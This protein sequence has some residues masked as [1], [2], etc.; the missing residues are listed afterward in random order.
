MHEEK[1]HNS[2]DGWGHIPEEYRLGDGCWYMD[3]ADPFCGDNC[4][5]TDESFLTIHTVEGTEKLNDFGNNLYK[6]Y[7][8]IKYEDLKEENT[9]IDDYIDLKLHDKI[10]GENPSLYLVYAQWF[11][12]GAWDFEEF[13]IDKKLNPKNL[14]MLTKSWGPEE[15]ITGFKYR[16]KK[17]EPTDSDGDHKWDRAWI[18]DWQKKEKYLKI[19]TYSES[20]E[21]DNM[22]ASINDEGLSDYMA[23][24]VDPVIFEK[25]NLIRLGYDAETIKNLI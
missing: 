6:E 23:F 1:S 3:Y 22:E 14:T 9:N 16:G 15:V 18:D 19:S 2:D 25:D 12:K 17:I 5:F 20:V 13:T 7:I 4:E 24:V 8:D 21:N 10:W 11:W